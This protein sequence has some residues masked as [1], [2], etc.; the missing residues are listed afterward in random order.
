MAP[1]RR[2]AEGPEALQVHHGVRL[3]PRH[4][5]AATAHGHVPPDAGGVG[6]R[7]LGQHPAHRPAAGSAAP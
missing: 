7:A 6:A 1:A 4:A 2:L 5:R 3:A